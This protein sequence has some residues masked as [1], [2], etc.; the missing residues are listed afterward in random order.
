MITIQLEVLEEIIFEWKDVD[1]SLNKFFAGKHWTVR[2]KFKDAF[3]LMFSKM[4]ESNPRI[5][6]KMI[7][8]YVLYLEYNSRLDPINTVIM[9]K[10]GEDYLRHID[11]L[12]DDTKQYCKAV[13]IVPINTMDKKHYKMR[14]KVLSY[15]TNQTQASRTNNVPAPAIRTIRKRNSVKKIRPTRLRK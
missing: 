9:M 13:I 8:K 4:I 12:T 15:A 1:V 2:N 14:F 6:D 10:I 11:A 5:T 3:H 7:D